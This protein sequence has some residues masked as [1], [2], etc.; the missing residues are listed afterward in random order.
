MSE[1]KPITES[2]LNAYLDGELD[3]RGREEVETWL[4]IH[5]EDAAKLQAWR[6]QRDELH[7]L[8]DPVLDEPIPPAMVET[9]VA[10][11]RGPWRDV[12]VRAVAAVLLVALG[13]VG[14]WN[15]R[16]V[17]SPDIEPSRFTQTPGP[18]ASPA[19]VSNAVNAHVV[20]AVEVRHPVEVGAKEEAHLVKWLSKRVGEPLR[21]PVL[22]A[23]GFH[24]MG[25]RLLSDGGRP[26]GQF[27][28]EDQAGRRVTLYLRRYDGPD[29]AFRFVGGTPGL[30]GRPSAFYWMDTPLAYALTADLPRKELLNL[31]HAAYENLTGKSVPTIH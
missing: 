4:A 3:P 22:I 26:A 14:G 17:G 16:G 19:F 2:D 12:W 28:Y 20:Y 18:G 27:M 7:R 5:P 21:A 1:L 23:A 29:T 24:L 13:G 10:A 30:Q 15:L 31:A 8:F 6:H 11:R 9:V 25:G